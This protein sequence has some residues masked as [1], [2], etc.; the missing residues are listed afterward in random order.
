M[1]KPKPNE[2]VEIAIHPRPIR[3]SSDRNETIYVKRVPRNIRRVP[4]ANIWL[5]EFTVHGEEVTGELSEH[6]WNVYWK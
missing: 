1:K 3:K 2:K 6:A 5:A 4:G